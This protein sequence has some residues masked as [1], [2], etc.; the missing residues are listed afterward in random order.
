[1]WKSNPA[2]SVAKRVK[3]RNEVRSRMNRAAMNPKTIVAWKAKITFQLMVITLMYRKANA[4][5]RPAQAK[6][7]K[8]SLKERAQLD[9]NSFLS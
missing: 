6:K 8:T 5:A 3:I 2:L 9:I 1:M 7:I 4:R